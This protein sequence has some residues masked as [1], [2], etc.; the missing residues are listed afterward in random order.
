MEID[1]SSTLKARYHQQEDDY[2]LCIRPKGEPEGK[3]GNQNPLV[4][5]KKLGA[6]GG[7]TLNHESSPNEAFWF[8]LLVELFRR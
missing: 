2:A 6:R 1:I 5:K 3:Q 8:G 7:K 4:P